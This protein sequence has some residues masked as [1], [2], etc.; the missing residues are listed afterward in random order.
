[1]PSRSG[2]GIPGDGVAYSASHMDECSRPAAAKPPRR[3][4]AGGLVL[5]EEEGAARLLLDVLD[6]VEL[7]DARPVVLRVAAVGD[8]ERLEEGVHAVEQR[9]RRGG[10][11]LDARLAAVDDD[12]VRERGPGPCG[13]PCNV[14][15][16]SKPKY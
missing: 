11:A 8:L 2:A 4:P 6:A 16:V 15:L 7:V 10:R 9:L 1:M 5:H 3:A 12:P 14:A 13:T